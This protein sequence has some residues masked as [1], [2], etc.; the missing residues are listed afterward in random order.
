[1]T[2]FAIVSFFQ[3][4]F[5][6]GFIFLKFFRLKNTG[7]LGTIIYSFGLSLLI[8]YLLVYHL[9]LAGIYTPITAYLILAVELILAI[10]LSL[11]KKLVITDRLDL[12][13]TIRYKESSLEILS[14]LYLSM[15]YWDRY[16]FSSPIMGSIYTLGCSLFLEPLGRRLVFK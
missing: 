13:A 8:N 9:T 5:I 10:I 2:A 3:I 15:L 12:E 4:V 14:L 11:K 7:I 6:P 16:I 1:M